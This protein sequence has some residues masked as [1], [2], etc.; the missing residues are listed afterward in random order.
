MIARIA[1]FAALFGCATLHGID[2]YEFITPYGAG[3]D[4]IVKTGEDKGWS[5]VALSL[6]YRTIEAYEGFE[7]NTDRWYYLYRWSRLFASR[8]SDIVNKWIKDLEAAK[9]SHTNQPSRYVLRNSPLGDLLSTKL[10]QHLLNDLDFSREFFELQSPYDNLVEVFTI[11]ETLYQRYPA[12]F[13]K[14]SRLALAI[15]MVYD[16]PPPPGWPHYQVPAAVLP[17]QLPDPA[18]AFDYWVRLS[19]SRQTAFD[20]SRLPAGQL[21]FV[22]DTPA[23][24]EEL[25]WVRNH[26]KQR[27][28]DF[29]EVYNTIDYRKDRVAYG[30]YIWPD[31]DYT[32]KTISQLGGICVDQAYYAAQAGKARG[33]PTLIFRGAGMDGRHAWFGF[34]KRDDVW[35][36]DAGRYGENQYV[37]GYAHDPQTWADITD[38]E[39][40]FLGEGFRDTYNYRQ[41]INHSNIAAEYID[42]KD[43]ESAR[44]ASEEALRYEK[45]N[46]VAWETL[47][48][49]TSQLSESPRDAEQVLRRAAQAFRAYPDL[50]AFY[51]KRVN[52]SLIDRGELSQA[53][54]EADLLARK[55]KDDRSDLSVAQA[56]AMLEQ[57][58]KQD[59]LIIQLRTYKVILLQMG[60][61]GGIDLFDRA[62]RPFVT[63]LYENGHQK[64]AHRAALLAR[65]HLE[66]RP[67]T[68]LEKAL[69]DLIEATTY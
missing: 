43:P 58:I 13:D 64:D 22:V 30:Q 5:R 19:D 60:K 10:K 45:R 34:L 29:A 55:N 9:L 50:E 48:T 68:M 38:H 37:T 26:V 67:G 7:E 62:I 23:S 4:R 53:R 1:I 28:E 63:H 15:A 31:Q 51:L 49:A 20:L 39:L 52:L 46:Q 57:S 54:R 11:L 33:I 69:D 12:Y 17:R 35:E 66:A 2:E 65:E 44:E 59:S 32:L 8:E 36:F 40:V 41:S 21:K 18:E 27:I 25:H 24:F 56:A 6:R 42:I 47:Y 16:V 3:I 14:Y 61:E